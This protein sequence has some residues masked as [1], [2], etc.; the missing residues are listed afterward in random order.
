MKK[1]F[2]II[3]LIFVSSIGFAQYDRYSKG[4]RSERVP[5][6]TKFVVTPQ[7]IDYVLSTPYVDTAYKFYDYAECFS[8]SQRKAIEKRCQEFVDKTGLGIAI[9][10]VNGIKWHSFGGFSPQESFIHDFY[11]Y[12]DFKPDGV[13]MLLNLDNGVSSHHSIFD[14]GKLYEDYFMGSKL[15]YYGPEM[16]AL[17]NAGDYYGDIMWFIEHVEEDYLYDISFP[18]WKCLIFAVIFGLIFWGIHL[19]KYKLKH[20]AT[21]ANNYKKEGS[22][23]LTQNRTDFVKTFTTKTYSPR[24]SGSSHGGRS[25]S[26]GGHSGG[27]F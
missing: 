25:S 10:V 20:L 26:G 18:L 7:N 13:M 11:D 22:F 17:Y 5:H 21:S 2:S 6:V 9:V 15:E 1:I 16:K 3:L 14:A 8:E 23:K 12:N 27:S 19:S 24:S 4:E